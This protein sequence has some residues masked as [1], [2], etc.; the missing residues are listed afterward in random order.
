MDIVLGLVIVLV[1]LPCWGGQA[2]S[3]LVPS[4]GERWKLTE[5][6]S[7]VDPVF[8]GDVRGEALWDTLTLWTMPLA[9]ALLIAGVDAW[10]TLGLVAGGIYCYFGGR[11]ILTRMAIARRG[12]QIGD[13]ATVN[14]AYAALAIWGVLGL[15]VIVGA[16]AQLA[17]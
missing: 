17:G 13:P 5:A 16:W 9:G 15:V 14:A 10:A 4:L 2:I 12:G 6:E 7:S 11:G 3:F 1:S 8:Y